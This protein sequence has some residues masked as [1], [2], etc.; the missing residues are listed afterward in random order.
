MRIIKTHCYHDCDRCK[1]V[2]LKGAL[3]YRDINNG[4][5]IYYHKGCYE[6]FIKPAEQ[7]VSK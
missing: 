7:V 4:K 2:I 6:Q 1:Q 5:V 3:C